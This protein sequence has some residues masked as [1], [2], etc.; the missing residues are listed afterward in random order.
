MLA[1][2]LL[3]HWFRNRWE[4]HAAELAEQLQRR[5]SDID[6]RAAML[7]AHEADIE[8]KVRSARLW[9]EERE[10]EIA[11]RE[12]AL[13]HPP[14]VVGQLDPQVAA[15]LERRQRELDS[16]Q[17][18]IYRKVEDIT[19]Q[20]AEL[21]HR[22][23]R[24]AGQEAHLKDLESSVERRQRSLADER[25][26]LAEQAGELDQ[27][28]GK[29]H[30]RSEELE[31]RDA[32]LRSRE[33]QLAMRRQ[34]IENGIRR[35]E[36]LGVT[37]E[38]IEQLDG[39]AAEFA[40]RSAYL[41]KAER[42]LKEDSQKLAERR[43]QLDDEYRESAEQLREQRQQ[44]LGEQE[45][46]RKSVSRRNQE[47][48]N[49]EGELDQ[50]EQTLANLRSELEASQREVL[51]IRLGHRRNVGSVN[52]CTGTSESHAKHRPDPKSPGRPIRTATHRAVRTS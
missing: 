4:R 9:F 2:P 17:A 38:R 27:R 3:R 45:S 36:Q 8:N 40:A 50:R 23:D 5:Q 42:L 46:F 26:D 15:E 31:A 28:R 37:Q 48:G 16:R 29:L 22:A 39:Q 20:T 35:F 47:L 52:R 33:M 51:E 44:L 7:A 10:R 30:H 13:E 21:D 11:E 34:E 18:E 41:D 25:Q 43:Q 1:S 24:L 49:R 14:A 6:R 12:A 32:E 19:Q